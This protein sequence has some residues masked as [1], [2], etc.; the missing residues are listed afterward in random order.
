MTPYR[1]EIRT[2]ALISCQCIDLIA[3]DDNEIEE[4]NVLNQNADKLDAIILQVAEKHLK[5]AQFNSFMLHYKEPSQKVII[6]AYNAAMRDGKDPVGIDT[7]KRNLRRASKRILDVFG[8]P[9]SQERKQVV[10]YWT[11]RNQHSGL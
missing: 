5:K 10:K 1:R 2:R 4:F 7:I 9:N 8:S 3:S 6:N 11:E